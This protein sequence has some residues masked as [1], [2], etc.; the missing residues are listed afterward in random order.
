MNFWR[1]FIPKFSDI[2]R[3]L[4]NLLRH[5]QPF[6]WTPACQTAFEDLKKVITTEPVLKA[7]HHDLPYYLETDLSGFADSGILLQKHD[8]KFHPIEFYSSSLSPAER[9]YT[10]PDQEFLAIVKSLTYW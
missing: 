2:A 8:G 1:K 7:P 10:T 4:H 5:D 3:P 6:E 9:N